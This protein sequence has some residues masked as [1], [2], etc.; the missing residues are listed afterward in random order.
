[1]G[2]EVFGEG[3]SGC[4]LPGDTGFHQEEEAEKNGSNKGRRTMQSILGKC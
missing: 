1:M 4:V 3:D 2:T